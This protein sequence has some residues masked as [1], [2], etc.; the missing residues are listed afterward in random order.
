MIRR[1]PFGAL[2]ITTL[3]AAGNAARSS[4]W[5]VN[6][7]FALVTPLGALLFFVGAGHM[8]EHHPAWLGMALAF[9]AGTFLYI[10]GAD[11]LPELQFRRHDRV[12]LTLALL[13]GVGVAVVIV[14]FGHGEDAHGH[15]AAPEAAAMH[16]ATTA[17]PLACNAPSW[18]AS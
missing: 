14:R 11:L 2:A 10:A 16:A 15:P 1:K 4:R 6:L 13:A 17:S 12:P 18:P 3:L 8:V 5:L 9:C 7:G